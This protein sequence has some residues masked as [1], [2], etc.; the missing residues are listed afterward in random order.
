MKF[1]IVDPRAEEKSLPEPSNVAEDEVNDGTLE[2][3]CVSVVGEGWSGEYKAAETNN[4]MNIPVNPGGS[5]NMK[6][7]HSTGIHWR[8]W[9]SEDTYVA[10]KASLVNALPGT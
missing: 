6:C 3:E 10:V 9:L 1:A 4:T 5:E 8:H 2:A 7:G